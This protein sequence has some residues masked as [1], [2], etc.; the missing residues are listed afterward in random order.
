MAFTFFFRDLPVIECAVEHAIS[1]ASGRQRFKVW[2]AGS[3]LGQETYT[4]AIVLAEK[5][6]GFAFKNLRLD[7]TDCDRANNFGDVVKDAVY[8][9]DEL[10]RMPVELFR[11]YFEPNGKRDHFRVVEKLRN[12][13]AFQYHDL[14]SLNPIGT[15]YSLVVCKNVLLHFSYEQRIEV[16]KMFHKALS[17]GGYFT[18]EHTQKLP[19]EVEHLFERVV[20]NAQLFRKLGG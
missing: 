12:Q 3:A 13:V 17:P 4:I 6:G 19:K 2:D 15:D 5:M 16:I 14:L 11:K 9:Y 8:H 18:S 20:P 1:F 10:K 7:A